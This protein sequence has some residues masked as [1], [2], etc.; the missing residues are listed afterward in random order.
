M[1]TTALSATRQL[2]R[3][4][5]TALV[6]VAAGVIYAIAFLDPYIGLFMAPFFALGCARGKH[7]LILLAL[8][9]VPA[10]V[11]VAVS[12]AKF[13]V[14]DMPLFAYDHYF[15]RGNLVLLAYNDWRVATALAITTAGTVYYIVHLF[16]GRGLFSRF[17]KGSLGALSAV[18]LGCI[19]DV[20]SWSQNS[21][22]WTPDFAKP[23]LRTLVYSSQIPGAQL[24]LPATMPPVPTL[25]NLNIGAP[26]GPLPDL[27]FVLQESTFPPELF[28]ESYEPHSLFSKTAP[29]TGPLHVHT[30]AGGTWRT[31]FSILTQMRPQEFGSDGLYVFH[32]LEGRIKRSIFT[33]LKALGYRTMV[34][35]PVPG[36]FINARNFYLSIGADEFNDPD[37]L[38]YSKG[39]DWKIP[40]STIYETML[41]KIGETNQPIAVMMLTINQH[42][43][44][45]IKDPFTDYVTRYSDSDDAYG[46]FLEALTKRGRPAGVVTF[47]DHQPE[48]MTRFW[49]DHA[50]WY[51]TA[52]DIRCI[53][54]ECAGPA[55]TGQANKALD[56]TLLSPF[57]LQ[58][59][60]FKLDD[61]AALQQEMFKNCDDDVMRCGEAT[62]LTYNAAFSRFF[63]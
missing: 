47:G 54:F 26:A 18:S 25:A 12:L 62:R 56:V 34:F 20:Q 42:T 60:G 50:K 33:E 19:V 41:K 51:T 32:Q 9:V 49:D 17:E 59:F 48:F 43:P 14:L 61:F 15:L 55:T 58:K 40:D 35:Y 52:Y 27:F 3:T 44:Y 30:F 24:L 53:N 46:A 31:E 63:E 5:T 21:T 36:S 7:P 37:T 4:Q 45:D 29:H 39:L 28:R 2:S 22:I 6:T 10:L 11:L 23:S 16:K 13:A 1:L 38:G 57:A 8:S